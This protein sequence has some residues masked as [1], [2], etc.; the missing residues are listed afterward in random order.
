MT[1]SRQEASNCPDCGKSLDASTHLE[2]DVVPV[3]G[4]IGVCLYCQG[5]HIF[6]ETLGR[7]VPTEEDIATMPLAAVSHLQRIL[8]TAKENNGGSE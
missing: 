2:D 8:T 3:P 7:R 5:I 6:T 1:T 4:D